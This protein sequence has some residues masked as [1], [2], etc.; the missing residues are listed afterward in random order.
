MRR[1]ECDVH[2]NIGDIMRPRLRFDIGT[3]DWRL[4]IE[5]ATSDNDD[6][7]QKNVN[8]FLASPKRTGFL[9]S[10][11]F[12]LVCV[13]CCNLQA[14]IHELPVSLS[15]G[16]Q[17]GWRQALFAASDRRTTEIK[18]HSDSRESLSTNN[19]SLRKHSLFW[20]E[21]LKLSA[22]GFIWPDSSTGQF[23]SCQLLLVVVCIVSL[24]SGRSVPFLHHN[25][26][27]LAHL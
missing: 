8:V 27:V 18:M 1:F 17:I 7:V 11:L 5:L 6:D 21:S 26:F 24:L 9:G 14:F 2:G 20:L 19:S 16:Q 15:V 3:G 12:K 25:F 10:V 4:A 13:C 23:N 22:S